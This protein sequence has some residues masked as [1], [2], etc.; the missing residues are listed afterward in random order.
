MSVYIHM[1]HGTSEEI[2]LPP[3]YLIITHSLQC[4]FYM[5][6]IYLEPNPK[7]FTYWNMPSVFFI[8]TKKSYMLLKGRIVLELQQEGLLYIDTRVDSLRVGGRTHLNRK[9]LSPTPLLKQISLH[10]GSACFQL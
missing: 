6:Q 9:A 8:Y 1:Q 4:N 5:D 10:S 2:I 7:V 3:S